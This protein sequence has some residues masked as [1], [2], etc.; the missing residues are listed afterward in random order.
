MSVSRGAAG[1]AVRRP[2]HAKT[3]RRGSGRRWEWAHTQR[4]ALLSS[5]MSQAK[6][7]NPDGGQHTGTS[8]DW[9]EG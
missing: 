3:H 9:R 1:A 6:G 5:S 7:Q 4:Q 2:V 8:Q